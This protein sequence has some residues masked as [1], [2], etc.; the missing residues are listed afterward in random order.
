MAD[1]VFN[2]AL[3]EVKRYA[4]LI[5]GA[6]DA[7]VVVLIKASGLEADGTLRD[8][9]TLS[10]LLASTN[11]ESDATN[12]VRKTISSTTITVDDTNNR[13]DIDFADQTWTALGGGT[14]NSIG[15]LL[16]C[17]DPD[18]TAGT[19]ADIVPLTFHD[20]TLTTD[21]SD[22]TAVVAASGFFRAS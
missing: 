15:K 11:D 5:D 3:G 18:T 10:A 1:G 19:D 6:N 14:N 16:V 12:Y 4:R 13:V 17:Y 7:L 22:V 8:H 21:G 9:D 2:I 20:F